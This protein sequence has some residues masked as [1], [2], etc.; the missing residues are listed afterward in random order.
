MT[1]QKI[2]NNILVLFFNEHLLWGNWFK[3]LYL[4]IVHLSSSFNELSVIIKLSIMLLTSNYITVK[5]GRISMSFTVDL[6]LI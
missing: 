2:T 1:L 6:L 5:K 3:N 4:T